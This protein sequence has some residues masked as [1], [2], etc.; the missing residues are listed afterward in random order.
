[1]N[2]EL[3]PQK[4]ALQIEKEARTC[5]EQI[6]VHPVEASISEAI[7]NDQLNV[8]SQNPERFKAVASELKNLSGE[9]ASALP[10]VVIATSNGKITGIDFYSSS[11]D[12]QNDKSR[13]LDYNSAEQQ[14]RFKRIRN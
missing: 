11:L 1:M 14:L 10:K 12:T 2:L 8:L 4:K 5:L 3:D 7:L 9:S 13:R 6:A